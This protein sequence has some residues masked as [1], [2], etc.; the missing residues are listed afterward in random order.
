MLGWGVPTFDSA[1][2]FTNLFHTRTE[3]L[4]TWNGTGYSNAEVDKQ[5]AS[6]SQSTESGARARE[7]SYIWQTARENRLYVPIHVQTLVY[8]MRKGV[9]ID[10]DISNAP[11]LKH[12]TISQAASNAKSQ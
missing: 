5:I 10:V 12:A 4:G 3:R 11:K 7:M 8:A 6:L 2:I 1:Y 9:R